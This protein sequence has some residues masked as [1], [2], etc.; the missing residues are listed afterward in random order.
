MIEN[1]QPQL[2]QEQQNDT[3]SRKVENE[4]W[5]VE[6]QSSGRM[7]QKRVWRR[8]RRERMNKE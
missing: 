2:E 7:G 1:S 8:R 5:N 3:E 6:T 4:E